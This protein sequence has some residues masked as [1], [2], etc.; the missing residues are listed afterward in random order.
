MSSSASTS[1][2][3]PKWPQEELHFMSLSNFQEIYRTFDISSQICN[4]SLTRR[5]NFLLTSLSWC[6]I[7]LY[8]VDLRLS[9]EKFKTLP[10]QV[11][12]ISLQVCNFMKKD[13]L[14]TNLLPSI[15]TYFFVIIYHHF[16]PNLSVS[17]LQNLWPSLCEFVTSYNFFFF[18]APTILWLTNWA[19]KF[20]TPHLKRFFFSFFFFSPPYSCA[21]FFM[22][23][24]SWFKFVKIS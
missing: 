9:P 2:T 15:S 17:F 23:L 10:W 4:F 7:D 24:F 5:F 16:S 1:T 12:D 20:V 18:L 13:F 21:T 22:Q 8:F 14:L 6:L 19:Q 11:C 3:C